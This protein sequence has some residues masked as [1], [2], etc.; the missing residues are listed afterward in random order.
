MSPII[1]NGQQSIWVIA[2]QGLVCSD[3]GLSFRIRTDQQEPPSRS[4]RLRGS[5]T[6]RKQVNKVKNVPK[7]L[8]ITL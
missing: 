3:S 6:E 8:T 5:T 1:N 4:S 7:I 2:R